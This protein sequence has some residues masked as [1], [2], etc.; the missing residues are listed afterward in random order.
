MDNSEETEHRKLSLPCISLEV[1]PSIPFSSKNPLTMPSS[2]RAQTTATSAREPLV[3]H[4]LFPL[5]IQSSPSFLHRVAIPPGFDPKFGS[6]R[7]KHPILVPLPKPD[8][9]LSFCS[10]DPYA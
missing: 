7:P 9:H 6:V 4:I 1:N 2:S 5:I 10:S 3:I 8:N